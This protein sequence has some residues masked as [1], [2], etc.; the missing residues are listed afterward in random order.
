M[1]TSEAKTIG[2]ERTVLALNKQQYLVPCSLMTKVLPNLDEGIQIVGFLKDIDV[3][4]QGQKQGFEQEERTHYMLYN[5][6][7][8]VVLGVTHSCYQQFGIPAS[9]VQGNSANTV[10][11]TLDSIAPDIVDPK[12]FEELK[13]PQ[14]LIV[15]LDTTSI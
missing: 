11:F 10:E 5:A 9:L 3:Q 4:L 6:Q 13:S 8:E 12:N 15:T 7:T 14:G 1:E 2:Q